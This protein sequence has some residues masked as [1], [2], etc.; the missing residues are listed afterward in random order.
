MSLEGATKNKEIRYGQDLE[1]AERRSL[2]SDID[3]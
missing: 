3:C 2:R 1:V